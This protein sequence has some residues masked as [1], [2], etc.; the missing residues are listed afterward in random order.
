[1]DAA[2]VAVRHHEHD[3]VADHLDH[4]AAQGHHRVVGQGLEPGDHRSQLLVPEVL[5]QHGE[6][7]HVREAH[8]HEGTSSVLG[9]PDPVEHGPP[10]GSLQVAAPDVLEEPGHH[11]QG[12][13]GLAGELV[14]VDDAVAGG[15]QHQQI[16]ETET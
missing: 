13:P 9:R 15:D 6:A 12:G 14:G 11:R 3:L 1:M 4:P 2:P 7:H 16:A 8:C 5:A 10:G